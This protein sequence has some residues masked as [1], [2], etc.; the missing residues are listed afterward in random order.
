LD[1]KDDII[2]FKP[3]W[4]IRNG[5]MMF[6]LLLIVLGMASFFIPYP[7]VITMQARLLPAINEDV[8]S[9]ML[10]SNEDA[11]ALKQNDE[12]TVYNAGST[13]TGNKLTRL[14]IM[15]ISAIGVIPDSSLIKTMV[16]PAGE[17]DGT[18]LQPGGAILQLTRQD[19]HVSDLLARQFRQIFSLN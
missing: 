10:V 17:Q 12:I 11:A 9:E 18:G 2:K 19:Q 15:S 13:H 8:I 5:T 1:N 16:R 6:L 7:R 4:L 14:R 3:G